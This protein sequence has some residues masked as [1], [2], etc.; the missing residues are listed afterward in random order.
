[1]LIVALKNPKKMKNIRVL[2]MKHLL[3]SLVLLGSTAHRLAAEPKKANELTVT[4]QTLPGGTIDEA[5]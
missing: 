2:M 5:R 1:M 4:Y 3:I